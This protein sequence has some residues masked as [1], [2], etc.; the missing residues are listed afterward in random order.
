MLKESYLKSMK[1]IFESL[2]KKT[3]IY[4]F[5]FLFLREGIKRGIEEIDKKSS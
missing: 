3:S 1:K 2:T 4:F 5:I